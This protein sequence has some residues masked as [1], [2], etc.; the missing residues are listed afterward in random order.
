[1]TEP[2]EL[3]LPVTSPLMPVALVVAVPVVGVEVVPTLVTEDELFG[4]EPTTLALPVLVVPVVDEPVTV[5]LPVP[6]L[7]LGSA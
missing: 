4:A 2:N 6:K 5:E 7:K 3:T 1:M